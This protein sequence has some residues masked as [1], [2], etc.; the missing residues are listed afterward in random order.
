[1][2][3]LEMSN[4]PSMVKCSHCKK[5]MSSDAFDAHKCTLEMVGVKPIP[6]VDYTDISCND[7]RI[8][9]G[10]GVDGVLYTFEVVPREPMPY[11]LPL[12]DDSYHDASNRRKVNR[13]LAYTVL[14][15]TGII[16]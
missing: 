15:K 8:I 13:T 16:K 2:Q 5:F 3:K 10:Q 6:V 4:S 9:M 7:K 12:S 14:N 1:M 11:I